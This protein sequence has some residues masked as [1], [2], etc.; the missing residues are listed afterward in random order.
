MG[1]RPSTGNIE[2]R[3]LRYFLAVVDE[4]SFSLA[5]EQLN[6]AQPGLSQQI[7]TLESILRVTLLDRSRR[8][9]RLTLAGEVFAK[10]IRR[11]LAQVERATQTA[12][13]AA[14]GEI[15]SLAIGYV[16]SAAYAGALTRLVGA[17]R[18]SHPDVDLEIAEM[19]MLSQIEAI[20]QGGLDIG[21][22]RPPVP[23]PDGVATVTVLLE[24]L[25]IALPGVHQHAPDAKVKL[26]DLAEDDFITPQHPPQVSFHAYTVDAC[27]KAGFH[28]RLGPQGRDF[29]TIASMVSVGLG[30]ALVPQ[31]VQCIQL[32]NVVYRPIAD[33]PPKGELALAY[34]RGDPSAAV[35]NFVQLARSAAKQERRP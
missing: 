4:M 21:F 16:G 15:G 29:M 13:R 6:I 12:Q 2:L 18:N 34:R 20:G 5:A 31:S 23:L 25:L 28:P 30:V 22:I 33:T 3:H 10:D 8:Q 14:R 35:Q 17:F 1:Q 24:D 9:L 26:T 7:K 32:P 11:I 27:G 19:E